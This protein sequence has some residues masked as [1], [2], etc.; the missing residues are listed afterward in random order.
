MN[1]EFERDLNDGIPSYLWTPDT[2]DQGTALT[3]TTEQF[4]AEMTRLRNRAR[5]R[6]RKPAHR[7]ALRAGTA[8]LAP[9]LSGTDEPDLTELAGSDDMPPSAFHP[10]RDRDVVESEAMAHA[11][12]AQLSLSGVRALGIY[13]DLISTGEI[14][15]PALDYELTRARLARYVAQ[16]ANDPGLLALRRTSTTLA[17]MIGGAA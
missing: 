5:R 16:N 11:R 17:F 15:L 8:R 9:R 7:R 10:A 14:A 3:M 2:L 1:D 12:S 4:N 13:L 6:S